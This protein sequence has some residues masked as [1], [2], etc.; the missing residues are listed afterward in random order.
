MDEWL[1]GWR[2]GGTV[3]GGMNGW[4]VDGFSNEYL[5]WLLF[6]STVPSSAPTGFIVLATSVESLSMTWNE[7][8]CSDWNGLIEYIIQYSRN[9][10]NPATII[11][12]EG[13]NTTTHTISGLTTCTNYSLT[14]AAKNSAGNGP[15]SPSVHTLTMPKGTV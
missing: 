10:G 4:M 13:S 8:P 14:I 7:L 15:F 1:S 2:E 3:G 9:D 12:V 6:N 11:V 5:Y